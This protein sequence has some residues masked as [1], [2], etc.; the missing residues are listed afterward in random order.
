MY[1]QSKFALKSFTIVAGLTQICVAVAGMVDQALF[2]EAHAT[3]INDLWTEIV[4][5]GT[6]AMTIYGRAKA[7]APLRWLP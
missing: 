6:G 1:Q 3:Q 5:L 2:T 7:I 4:M